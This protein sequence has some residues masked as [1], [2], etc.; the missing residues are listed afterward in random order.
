VDE[1]LIYTASIM[2]GLYIFLARDK[3]V[4]KGNSIKWYIWVPWI[5]AIAILAGAAGGY[6]QIDFFY[7]T[8][9]GLSIGNVQS[10]IAYNLV[11]FLLIVMPAFVFGKRSFCHHLCW[12]VPFM[13]LGRTIRNYF[14]WNSLELK[15]FSDNCKHC[16]ACTENCPMS[17]PVEQIV[18]RK[19][20]EN[21][22]CVL[23]GRCVDTCQQGAITFYWGKG[24]IS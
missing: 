6:K 9:Y 22:E 2:T 19:T 21:S 4:E 14:C 11:L 20:M 10:L 7:E 5:G 23:C 13:I 16:H 8:T 18:H 12:M 3:R 24:R 17:L 1:G 15:S